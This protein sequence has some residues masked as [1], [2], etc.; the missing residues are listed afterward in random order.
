MNSNTLSNEC[1]WIVQLQCSQLMSQKKKK[2]KKRKNDSALG[3]TWQDRPALIF[4][5]AHRRKF[6][7]LPSWKISL[8]P[9]SV[10]SFFVLVH[11]IL[12][13][14]RAP[15]KSCTRCLF[16]R[17]SQRDY[18]LEQTRQAVNLNCLVPVS[19]K[20][21]VNVVDTLH[22]LLILTTEYRAFNH[23]RRSRLWFRMEKIHGGAFL[24]NPQ[25]H[26]HH[27]TGTM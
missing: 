24:S 10:A 17:Y 20:K 22:T 1:E 8:D 13:I 6:K 11:V 9:R 16:Q 27:Y 21:V 25:K 5:R 2:R 3:K 23:A 7:L 12:R 19:S 26:F 4:I 14:Q 15:W 18:R